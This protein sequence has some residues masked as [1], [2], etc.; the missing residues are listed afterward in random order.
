MRTSIPTLALFAIIGAAAI[1]VFGGHPAAG[2]TGVTWQWTASTTRGVEA[3]VAVPDPTAYTIRFETDRTFLA[4]AD[5]NT[6]AGTYRTIPPGRMGPLTRIGMF[7]GP[8]SLA[9]CGPDSLSDAYVTSL[10]QAVSY[11]LA[12]GVLTMRLADG[13]SMT[14]R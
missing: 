4:K 6:V 2:V 12:E 14:F 5:C 1:L 3:P 9:A 13:G 11:D 7:P 8:D 10:R